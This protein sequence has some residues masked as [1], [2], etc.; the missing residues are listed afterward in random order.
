MLSNMGFIGP[1]PKTPTIK[2]STVKTI[3]LSVRK[4]IK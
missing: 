2:I 4:V 1:T 3:V